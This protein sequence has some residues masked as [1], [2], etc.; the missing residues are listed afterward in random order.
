MS[1]CPKCDGNV[2]KKGVLHSG[3]VIL[4]MVPASNTR[5]KSS[6]VSAEYCNDC[7]YIEA[8]YVTELKNLQ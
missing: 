2:L 4:Q 8:L 7:G 5:G 3:A 6:P 1:K